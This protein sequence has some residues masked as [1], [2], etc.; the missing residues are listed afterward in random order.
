M[1]TGCRARR[2]VAAHDRVRLGCGRRHRRRDGRR[3]PVER[4]ARVGEHHWTERA[5]ALLSTL[6]HAA[7]TED[8]SMRDVLQWID[9]H[10]GAPALEILA[11]ATGGDAPAA[12]LLA[13]IVATDSREQSGIWSTA[14]GVLAAYRTEGALASTRAAPW[15]SRRSAAAPT[16]SIS[17]QPVGGSVNSRRSWWPSW[18]M[19]AMP[20]TSGPATGIPARP[21][22]SLSTRSPTSR[23]S[24]ISRPW[25]ARAPGQ[26]LLVLACLQDLSQARVR[27]G[28]AADGFLSLFGTTVVLRGI[29]DTATLR[30]IS[31]LAGDRE[32]AATTDQPIGGPLGPSPPL[33]IGG[34]TR[35]PASRWMRWRTASPGHALV[36]GPDKEVQEVATHARA[37]PRRPGVSS[38]RRRASSPRRHTRDRGPLSQRPQPRSTVTGSRHPSRARAAATSRSVRMWSARRGVGSAARFARLAQRCRGVREA[39]PVP[40][41]VQSDGGA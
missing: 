31:A 21:P 12:D 14:S 5:G 33:D 38:C 27:W 39:P 28:A 30:D 17:A 22:C 9:R 11:A 1:P 23:P 34:S 35:R 16:P 24:P 36:L 8:L 20:P 7:A 6:L 19:C 3:Q 32:V 25:S 37:R 2:L 26:G 15:T 18:A 10:N 41:G 13:G 4:A 40:V 29:A